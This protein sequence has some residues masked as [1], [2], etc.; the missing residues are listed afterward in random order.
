MKFIYL[1]L[2]IKFHLFYR[3][4]FEDQPKNGEKKK[5][6]PISSITSLIDIHDKLNEVIE[7]INQSYSFQVML[8][9]AFM[10]A[11]FLMFLFSLVT[12]N[13]YI[14]LNNL[15]QFVSSCIWNAYHFS[16][17]IIVMSVSSAATREGRKTSSIVHRILNQN[18]NEDVDRK[19]PILLK[20]QKK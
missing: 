4:L 17:I 6:N 12:F 3:R 9:F 8:Y 2:L 7:R 16:F 18:L 14:T 20:K 5:S 11:I 10:C 1:E 15:L 19:V 13:I